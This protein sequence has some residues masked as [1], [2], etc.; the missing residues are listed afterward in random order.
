MVTG[1]DKFK[2]FFAD[3]R[4]CY[5]LIGGSA[6]DVYFTDQE[7]PFR[8]TYDLDM[9][10]CVEALTPAFF[11]RFWQ[12]IREGG[13][14]HRQKKDIGKHKNDIARIAATVGVRDY[15]LPVVIKEKLRSFMARYADSDIDVSA[16]GVPVS[17]EEIKRR[18]A[19]C[20]GV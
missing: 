15:G 6:C 8:V 18:L 5:V 14:E 7:L 20:F 4:D 17:G 13:Y 2:E 3:Y 16:L 10:L 12:F 11:N 19:I 1:L 9:I